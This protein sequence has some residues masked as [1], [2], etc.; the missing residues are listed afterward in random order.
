MIFLL[1]SCT[2]SQP[3]PQ[4]Y[5]D[6]AYQSQCAPTEQVCRIEECNDFYT[7]PHEVKS[8]IDRQAITEL[9]SELEED[10][11]PVAQ[12]CGISACYLLPTTD[13]AK[14]R[15]QLEQSNPKA[16]GQKLARQTILRSMIV[17]QTLTQFISEAK[18][19]EYWFP[20]LLSEILCEEASMAKQLSIACTSQM[21][22]A[23]Q[24]TLERAEEHE[25]DSPSYLS[26]L[27]LAM[28]LDPKGTAAHLMSIAFD[29]K[30]SPKSRT[31]ASRAIFF[32]RSRGYTPSEDIQALIQAKCQ[33]PNPS[34][35]YLCM[36]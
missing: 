21:P 17:N 22:K 27:N 11:S 26:A 18:R 15:A 29:E 9:C 16:A 23:A 32:A 35:R 2:R 31:A 25:P 14:A 34:L 1:L 6:L 33:I 4:S 8:N 36:P 24:A 19:S 20:I 5:A 7:K 13:Y 30:Q 3:E 10:N 28:L 12:A